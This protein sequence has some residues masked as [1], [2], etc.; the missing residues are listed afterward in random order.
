V[1]KI[2][3][4]ARIS[5]V[6][7]AT[8]RHYDELGLLKPSAV[9]RW[10][11]YRYY[12]VSQLPRLNR[13]LAL[14]DLGFSLEQIEAVLTGLTLDQLHG[15]LKMKQ[16]EVE[17]QVAQEQARLARIAA[18]L[19]QIEEEHT[20]SNFDVLVKTVPAMR[21]AARRVTI[22][23]NDQAPNFLGPGFTEVYDYV[24][25][26]GGKDVGPCFAMWHQSAEVMANEVAEVAVAVDRPLPST[27]R[28]QVYELP[29]AQVASVVHHGAFESLRPEHVALL[30]WIEANHYQIAGPYREVY[31]NHDRNNMAESATE[32]QYPIEQDPA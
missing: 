28:V 20:M 8:L 3:D 14:K 7:V 32:V 30:T 27:E 12:S 9:D 18:R 26:A 2:G 6:S 23:T 25:Q 10:T 5:Q 22:P 16:A 31:I 15:M 17:Q 4:F 21:I 24:T 19:R 11:G 1:I 29:A 13:I